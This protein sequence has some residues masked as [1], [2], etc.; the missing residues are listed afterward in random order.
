MSRAV[1]IAEPG[2]THEGNITAMLRLVE[3]AA[4]IGCGVF[5]NQWVSSP[6]ELCSRRR[7]PEYLGAYRKISYPRVWHAVIADHCSMLSL[8]YAC[9]VYLPAD[10]PVIEPYCDY[11]KCAS[12]EA[13]DP[14]MF[15]ALW[16]Y[17][18]KTI[19]SFG[20]GG[21]SSSFGEFFARLH[22]ISAYP[23]PDD[24][25]NLA[26]IRDRGFD[27]LS[28]HSKHPWTGAL[29]VAAGARIVEFHVRLDDTS[30]DNAD[31]AVAR[32]P[33]EARAYV[34]HIR[35]AEAMLGDGRQ[36]VMEAEVGMLRYRVGISP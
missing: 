24:Q 31:Y 18:R 2:S 16:P 35:E 12:F 22:C 33:E 32:T 19:V 5:K 10:A 14:E 25:M 27:G 20:M 4:D 13:G 3:L 36:R 9:S 17:R 6:E 1:I 15:E 34:Q 26:A 28:D 11:L 30:P 7:A 29:V 8:R 23:A 21:D